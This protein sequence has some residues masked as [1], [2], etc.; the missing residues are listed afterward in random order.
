MSTTL[1]TPQRLSPSGA[2]KLPARPK[3]EPA[4]DKT[5]PTPIPKQYVLVM[6]HA[7]HDSLGALTP[8]GEAECIEIG[9]TLRDVLH[10]VVG[11][12]VDLTERVTVLHATSPEAART[13]ELVAR[14]VYPRLE[15]TKSIPLTLP[16]DGLYTDDKACTA[17]IVEVENEVNLS[18]KPIVLVVGHDPLLSW[19]VARIT[20]R[21][22]P[23]D[24]AE[25][26]AIEPT[27]RQARWWRPAGTLRWVL[28]P[29]RHAK[30]VLPELREKIKSKMDAAKFLATFVTA[31]LGFQLGLMFDTTKLKDLQGALVPRPA[32]AVGL[33]V[34]A[35]L[36]ALSAGLFFLT[37]FAYDSLLM[38]PS[39]WGNKKPHSLA[40]QPRWLVQRPPS[41][42]VWIL[43][44]NM[45]RVWFGIFTPGVFI[46]LA[47]L[48]LEAGVIFYMRVDLRYAVPVAVVMVVAVAACLTMVLTR[49]WPRLGSQ[50]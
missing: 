36:L 34:A 12:S 17:K 2:S 43:L 3:K 40:K 21:A 23:I 13:A 29:G 32:A 1:A 7:G 28:T 6:R 48:L 33:A 14:Q 19:F 18:K 15:C 20:G 4:K 35:V 31:T 50:D 24:R 9:R 45:Q 27:N 16:E 22:F 11:S 38:P 44:Q 46:L 8:E 10:Q 30:E 26:L 5:E 41:S 42:S 47:A 39:L 49:A 37:I 25:L